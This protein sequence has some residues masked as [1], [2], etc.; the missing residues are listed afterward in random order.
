MNIVF[1]LKMADALRD[2][3]REYIP[4]SPV[5]NP[6]DEPGQYNIPYVPPSPVYYLPSPEYTPSAITTIPG[7]DLIEEE[8]KEE[9]VHIKFLDPPASPPPDGDVSLDISSS[10]LPQLQTAYVNPTSD[11]TIILHPE[12]SGPPQGMPIPVQISKGIPPEL[13]SD[14]DLDEELQHPDHPIED[15][16]KEEGECTD[17][18]DQDMPPLVDVSID[19]AQTKEFSP[20]PWNDSAFTLEE[21]LD[22]VRWESLEPEP[23][24]ELYG[25]N[26]GDEQRQ[27]ILLEVSRLHRSVDQMKKMLQS[28]GESQDNLRDFMTQKAEVKLQVN[29]I[30]RNVEEITHTV[31]AVSESQDSIIINDMNNPDRSDFQDFELLQKINDISNRM[32]QVNLDQESVKEVMTELKSTLESKPRNNKRG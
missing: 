7:L 14:T 4:D 18:D 22:Q 3:I 5:Y 1:Y 26:R 31:N 8:K 11:A 19:E 12:S 15:G 13:M 9:N 30:N 10:G 21:R 27:E 23:N 2:L 25:V 17:E 20:D 24:Y 28:I 6:E 32:T 29:Q 16:T